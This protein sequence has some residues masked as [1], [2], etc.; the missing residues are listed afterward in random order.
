MSPTK[1]KGGSLQKQQ[2]AE[3]DEEQVGAILRAGRPVVRSGALRTIRTMRST[4]A[5]G[6]RVDDYSTE[7]A[8]WTR[9]LG[10][11]ALR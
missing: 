5:S 9:E 3:I 11:H 4:E 8:D 6:D 1:K 7:S 2:A 10:A